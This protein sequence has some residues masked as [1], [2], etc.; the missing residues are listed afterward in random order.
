M[1]GNG[2]IK[3]N[4]GCGTNRLTGWQ[5]YDAEVDITQ[6]LPFGDGIADFMFAEHVVEH[7]TYEQALAFF[8]ECYRVL[9]RGGVLRIAVPSIERVM[10]RGDE[11]YFTFA[12]KWTK[13]HEVSRRAAMDAI[14]HAH[15]HQA[16]WTEGLLRASLY[17]AGFDKGNV[18]TPGQSQFDEL[19]N[20]EGHGKVIG[21]HFN[22]IETAVCEGNK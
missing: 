4:F 18:C 3:I 2:L 1:N 22:F 7:V 9:K 13:N 21:D 10:T 20:V 6:P 5:N 14:L 17:F 16:P 11:S 19:R 8:R 15:G 12:S